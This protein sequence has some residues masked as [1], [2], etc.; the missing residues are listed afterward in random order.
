MLVRI[1]FTTY[2]APHS[3]VT[4]HGR[5]SV[6]S[7][8]WYEELS[9]VPSDTLLIES[10]QVAVERIKEFAEVTR[11]A[12]E[13]TDSRA[14]PSWPSRGGIKCEDLAVR[15]AVSENISHY[16]SDSRSRNPLSLIFPTFF[17]IST[18]RSLLVKKWGY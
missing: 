16:Y 5:S 2:D 12:P 9:D 8:L 10:I 17:T 14:P 18:L 1:Y 13:Y 15:Y 4:R 11:E 3:H 6:L 7:C